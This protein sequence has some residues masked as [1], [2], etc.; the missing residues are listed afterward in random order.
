M[1]KVSIYLL[2]VVLSLVLV[3]CNSRQ[4]D[5]LENYDLTKVAELSTDQNVMLFSPLSSAS[6]LGSNNQS[7]LASNINAPLPS[8]LSNNASSEVEIDME[9]ANSYLLIMENILADGGPIVS[10][11]TASDREGYDTMM[12]VTVKDLAGNTKSYTIYYSVL[13]ESYDYDSDTASPDYDEKT[14]DRDYKTDEDTNTETGDIKTMGF[15]LRSDK[16]DDS[17]NKEKAKDQFKKHHYDYEYEDEIEYQINA[18]AVIDG[19]EYEVRGSKEVESDYYETEVEIEFVVKLDDYNYVKIKQ[20]IENNELEY[21][22]TVYQ[23]GRKQTSMSFES[24]VEG[25]NTVVKL[26]TEENGFKETYKFIKGLDKTI[27]K[28]DGNGYSYTL[29]VTSTIDPQTNEVVYEYKVQEKEYDWKY[30]KSR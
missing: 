9:K 26:T 29:F 22:Y 13:A 14:E 5:N 17:S 20:E 16:K 19:V 30:R 25:E 15:G 3:G 23:N 7:N 18:L 6:I 11:E 10:S 21:K 27:I 28:Y 2:I 4:K 1:K 24:E 12:V 8:Y